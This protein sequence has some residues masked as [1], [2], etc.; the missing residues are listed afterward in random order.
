LDCTK[1]TCECVVYRTVEVVPRLSPGGDLRPAG[2]GQF[3]SNCCKQ[4][5]TLIEILG[6]PGLG[7]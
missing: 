5:I 2:Y 1:E 6:S 3:E 7:Q 4:A